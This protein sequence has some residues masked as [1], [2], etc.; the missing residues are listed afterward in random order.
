[1]VH[2]E[3]SSIGQTRHFHQKKPVKDVTFFR[4]CVTNDLIY[5]AFFIA[6]FF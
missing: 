3:L 1:M 2:D 6:A 4:N 5:K